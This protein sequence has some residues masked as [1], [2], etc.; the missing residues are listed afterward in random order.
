[1]KIESGKYYRTRDGRKIGP[2]VEEYPRWSNWPFEVRNEDG[3]YPISICLWKDDGACDEGSRYDL[4]SEWTDTPS[5]PSTPSTQKLWRD[6]TP[7]EKG[8]LLL[9]HHEGKVIE[10]TRCPGDTEFCQSSARGSRPVWDD[11]HAYRV[12]PEPT[13]D[14]V[15]VDGWVDHGKWWTGKKIPGDTHRITFNLID[16]KPDCASIK[17]E[18]L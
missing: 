11:K 3:D 13:V 17:M 5:T 12:K 4:V 9:A 7:E 16:G 2:M 8:A 15:T 10:W 14:T 6:M 18:E 1:M